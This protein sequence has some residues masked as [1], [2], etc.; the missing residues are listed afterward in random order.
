MSMA[1]LHA[2]GSYWLDQFPSLLTGALPA[3]CFAGEFGWGSPT[4]RARSA[5]WR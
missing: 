4:E 5:A 3:G 2:A 1:I